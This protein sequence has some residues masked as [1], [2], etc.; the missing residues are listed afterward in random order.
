MAETR[1]S[2]PGA[3][4]D[5]ARRRQPRR[6]EANGVRAVLGLA[7]LAT[8]SALATAMAPSIVSRPAEAAVPAPRAGAVG[9]PAPPVVRVTRVITLAPGQTPPPGA[10]VVGAAAPVPGA[11]PRPT[12]RVI[13]QTVTRQSGQP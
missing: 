1:A 5:E 7:G 3:A 13:V 4:S 6:S 12:P 2:S 8:A 11:T 10:V 9:A